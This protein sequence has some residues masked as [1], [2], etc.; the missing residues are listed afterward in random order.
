LHL[1]DA[2]VVARHRVWDTEH[3]YLDPLNVRFVFGSLFGMRAIMV[4]GKREE[5]V[6]S[7]NRVPK[8]SS[9][10][11][12][13]R[14]LVLNAAIVGGFFFAGFSTVSF[15]WT[16][17]VLSLVPFFNAL[18]QLLEHRDAVVLVTNLIRALDTRVALTT[19]VDLDPQA[20]T[21]AKANG[22]E[23]FHGRIEDYQPAKRFDFILA[24]NLIEHL[25][26]PSE[27]LVKLRECLTTEGMLLIKTPNIDSLDARLFRHRNWGGFHCPRHWVLFDKASFLHVAREAGLSVLQFKFTQGAP[28]WAV[29]ILAALRKRGLVR[30]DAS[31]PAFRHPLYRLLIVLFGAFDLMRSPFA[32]PSQM[33]CILRRD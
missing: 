28:F 9:R 3:S 30:L 26:N 13:A 2:V 18:R 16:L 11:A 21:L 15:A 10:K 27:V 31:R 24:L 12:L 6:C 23:Y 20:E 29:S 7:S 33:F 8:R 17:G 14:G 4:A 32:S 1:R 22:H 5:F 25:A 19:V